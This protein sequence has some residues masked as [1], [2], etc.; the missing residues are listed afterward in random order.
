MFHY[1]G[2]KAKGRI[3][4]RVQQENKARQNTNISYLLIRG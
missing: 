3:L 1:V 2:N 4:N